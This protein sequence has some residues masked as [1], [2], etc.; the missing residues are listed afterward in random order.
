MAAGLDSSMN[1][2]SSKRGRLP[3]DNRFFLSFWCVVAA[4][5]AYG[6]MYAFR[7]PFTAGTFSTEPFAAGFKT[8]LVLAQVLGYTISKFIGIKVIA[9]MRPERRV[10]ILLGLVA[11]SD[12]AHRPL[13]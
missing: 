7:K 5:G 3:F 11:F 8:W 4:F 6:C 2:P 12:L 13:R 1:A 10:M 9:E